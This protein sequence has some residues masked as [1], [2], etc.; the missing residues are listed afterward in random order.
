MEGIFIC[1]LSPQVVILR[2]VTWAKRME[3]SRRIWLWYRNVYCILFTL[4][5][6]AARSFDSATLRSGWHYENK[7]GTL[8]PGSFKIFKQR[9]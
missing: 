3:R 9:M 8:L 7:K 1:L 2:G 4:R 6:L 5:I